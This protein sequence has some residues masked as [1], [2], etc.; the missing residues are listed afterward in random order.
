[1]LILVEVNYGYVRYWFKGIIDRLWRFDF[2]IKVVFIMIE[3]VDIN[4]L[5]F[6]VSVLML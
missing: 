2:I 6:L 5:F 1:M 3:F 4:I